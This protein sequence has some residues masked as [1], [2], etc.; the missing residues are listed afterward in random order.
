MIYRLPLLYYT[1]E[2]QLVQ[3]LEVWL[4]RSAAGMSKLERSTP[5]TERRCTYFPSAS[6]T[7]TNSTLFIC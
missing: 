6:T 3:L 1:H 7:L 2:L 4:S 5:S